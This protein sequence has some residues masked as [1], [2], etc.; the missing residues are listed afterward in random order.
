[1]YLAYEARRSDLA[2]WIASH[3]ERDMIQC[4]LY[5]MCYYDVGK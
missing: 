2:L 1:M 4:V 3:I 5:P